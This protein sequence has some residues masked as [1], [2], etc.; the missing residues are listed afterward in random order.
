MVNLP[1]PSSSTSSQ[2]SLWQMPPTDLL[3]LASTMTSSIRTETETVIKKILPYMRRREYDIEKDFDFETPVKT[4]ERANK[5]YADI[6]VMCGQSK[7]LFVIEAKKSG[8][9][10]NAQDRDQA[11]IYGTALGALFVVVTNGADI[12]CYNVANRDLLRWNGKLSQKI[13][14]RSQLLSNVVRTLRAN[15]VPLTNDLSLPF[16]P[17]LPLKQLNALFARCHNAIRKIEKDEDNAFADFSKLLFLKLLEEKADGSDFTLPYSY[18][19]YELA[20][21]PEA[22]ADQIQNAVVDMIEKI[23]QRT[24]YGDVLSDPLKMSKP[25]TFRYIVRELAAVS[26]QDIDLDYKGAA[27]EYFVR[28]TLKGKKLGQ[29]FTP[30]EL[31]KLMSHLVGQE[32]VINAI[33]S[34]S[35]IKVL[36]PACGTGGFLVYLM[37]ENLRTLRDRLQDNKITRQNHDALAKKVMEQVFF[38]SDANNGVACAAKMN[39]IIAGDGHTNI[40]SEDSL[41]ETARN[42]NMAEPDCDL[43]LTNPPFGTSE[44]NSMSSEELDAYDV[45]RTKGQLLFLQ[46]MIRCVVKEGDICTVIDEGVL[47]T[48]VAREIR[49]FILQSC[50][51][52]A[53]VRL[54]EDT[55]KPNKINVRAS[56]LYLRRREHDD[57]DLDED[58]PITF[59]D[60]D[61]L[62]YNGAGD[63]VRGFD[64]SRLLAESATQ[65]LD[66]GLPTRNGYHWTAFNVAAQDVTND[67]TNRLDYKYWSPELRKHIANLNASGGRAIKQLNTIKTERGA[68]P[69]AE[70]YV[71]EADGYALVVKAGSNISRYGE[72]LTEGDYI[73]KNVYDEM[74][75]A[76][77]LDG[78]V[79]L[80]STG[81]GTIG[82]CCVYR[83]EK[84]AIA[85]GHVTIIRP[86]TNLISP[87]YLC[88]YLRAGF[89]ATQVNRLFTGSTGLVEL[90]KDHVDAVM[91]NLLSGIDEQ[92][93]VSKQLRESEATYRKLT[94][95]AAEGLNAARFLFAAL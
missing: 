31:I 5:G 80:S 53:V 9:K 95:E 34:G 4:P 64:L 45:R 88:D 92:E 85:D 49:R 57:V 10:L 23:K 32:K 6:L 11:L 12:Q 82:K 7:P 43:I 74:T 30:R 42:W 73:E 33:T 44:A 19:F 59:C 16:R 39:M 71:D 29:Y 3:S 14:T 69:K 72:L 56:I 55:F 24:N 52:V 28:A 20:E 94:Q 13:P 26:F 15:D 78:D 62:G 84:P 18:R 48:E 89:G 36:D 47:N 37:Q 58:Y 40:Q 35:K 38:G 75:R 54:P 1:H 76:H 79:L 41:R 51:V 21:K 86:D 67:A 77:I 68:S 17:S 66:T 87:E 90:A 50:R 25:N 63:P 46:K 83:S 22:E 70:L 65:F 60:V 93:A 27:F 8:K 61:S 81:D 91:I 2:L